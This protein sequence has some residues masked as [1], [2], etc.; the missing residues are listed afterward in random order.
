M[1]RAG[2]TPHR[3]YATS[4]NDQY[5]VCVYDATTGPNEVIGFALTGNSWSAT[6]ITNASG[7]PTAN[8]GRIDSYYTAPGSQLLH[9]F[10]AAPSD[11]F[12]VD[13]IGTDRHVH[14]IYFSGAWHTDDLALAANTSGLDGYGSTGS[15]QSSERRL[16]RQQQPRPPALQQ[17]HLEPRRPLKRAGPSH[18]RRCSLWPGAGYK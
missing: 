5:V 12:H 11:Q 13:Y 16:H 4:N 10:G 9:P 7:A 15:R 6:D 8:A 1:R 3:R 2:R 14:E 18:R 17:R